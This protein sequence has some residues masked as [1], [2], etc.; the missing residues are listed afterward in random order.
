MLRRNLKHK[1]RYP[2]MTLRMVGTPILLL[3]LFVSVSAGRS[4]APAKL[5]SDPAGDEHPG[6]GNSGRCFGLDALLDPFSVV[7]MAS[8]R[9]RSCRA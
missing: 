5:R 4:P 6:P 3:V 9:R 8:S 2:S 1:L 7:S